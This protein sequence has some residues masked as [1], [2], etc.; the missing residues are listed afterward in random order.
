MDLSAQ[1]RRDVDATRDYFF[2]RRLEQ[3]APSAALE[4]E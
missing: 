3:E 1:I 2:R 4:G